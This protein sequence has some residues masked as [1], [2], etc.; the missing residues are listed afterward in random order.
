LKISKPEKNLVRA[1]YRAKVANFWLDWRFLTYP[2]H[3]HRKSTGYPQLHRIST[4]QTGNCPQIHRISTG[5]PL[6]Y[7]DNL[8]NPKRGHYHATRRLSN[9]PQALP[10]YSQPKINR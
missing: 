4:G 6:D 5:F 9:A 8:K 1:V 3:I 2:P 10:A 7:V